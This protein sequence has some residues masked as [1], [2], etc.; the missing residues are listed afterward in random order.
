MKE[1]ENLASL[2]LTISEIQSKLVEGCECE[3]RC[4][5]NEQPGF[6]L[7]E[8]LLLGLGAMAVGALLGVQGMVAYRRAV[9]QNLYFISFLSVS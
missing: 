1:C 6:S 5:Q 2:K 8:C 3:A 9:T 7:V 4:F